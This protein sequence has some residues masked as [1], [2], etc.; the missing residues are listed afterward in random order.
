MG[1]KFRNLKNSDSKLN[2]QGSLDYLK[3]LSHTPSV[4]CIVRLHY[5]KAYEVTYTK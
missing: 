5:Y 3:L 2:I 4:S 1:A